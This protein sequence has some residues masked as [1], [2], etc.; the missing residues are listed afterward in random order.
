MAIVDDY[1][2]IAAQLR[3][4]QAEP[5]PKPGEVIR[6]QTQVVYI[7]RRGPV[8]ISIEPEHPL[9]RRTAGMK[10]QRVVS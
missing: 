7:T 4:I 10:G 1:A 8:R 3:R 6:A 9:V 5:H 2:G